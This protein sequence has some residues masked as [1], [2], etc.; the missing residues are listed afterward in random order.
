MTKVADPLGAAQQG[1]ADV[2]EALTRDLATI[3]VGAASGH[4]LEGIHVDHGGRRRRLIELA[5]ISIPDP[6]QIV[7]RPWDPTSL[8]AIGTAIS[9]SR[10]GLT[11]SLDGPMIRIDVPATTEERRHELVRLVDR[12]VE[13]GHV[14]VRKIRHAAMA[15]IRAPG[16]T[17]LGADA[18]R[19]DL[20]R[21]QRACDAT[22]SDVDRLGRVKTAAILRM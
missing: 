13:R 9:R 1:L 4:L 11:P 18:I 3:R 15:A 17:A 10:I 12:R 16:R 14:D 22:D 20:D 8:R 21:L 6:R 7:I 19:R 5:S 2:V